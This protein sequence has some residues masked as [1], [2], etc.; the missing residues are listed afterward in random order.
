RAGCDRHNDS[1]S[2]CLETLSPWRVLGEARRILGLRGAG[3]GPI[4]PIASVGE[5]PRA[6]A[7]AASTR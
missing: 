1:R 7:N 5:P 4:V 2:E 3:D 6:A